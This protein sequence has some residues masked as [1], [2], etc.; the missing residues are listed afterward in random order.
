SFHRLTSFG[1]TVP[2][3]PDNYRSHSGLGPRPLAATNSD[4]SCSSF[5]DWHNTPIGQNLNPEQNYDIFC[6]LPNLLKHADRATAGNRP[7]VFASVHNAPG[8]AFWLGC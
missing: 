1:S 4:R 2:D 3:H 5:V 6:H 7:L 8:A